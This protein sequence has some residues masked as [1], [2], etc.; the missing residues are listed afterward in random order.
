MKLFAIRESKSVEKI[1]H[2]SEP[3]LLFVTA[4]KKKSKSFLRIDKRETSILANYRSRR[5]NE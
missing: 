1:L 2:A 3:Q 4:Q 5:F